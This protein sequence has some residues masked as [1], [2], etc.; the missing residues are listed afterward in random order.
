MPTP[1][2]VP[3]VIRFRL[4]GTLQ[5]GDAWGNRL[6]V[7]YTGSVPGAPSV[8][9][10]CESIASEWNSTW[11]HLLADGT[12]LTAVDGVDLSSTDGS[13]ATA[14]VS[15]AGGV[16]E[17]AMPNQVAANVRF[18]IDRRYRGG[19]PKAYVAGAPATAQANQSSW[20]TTFV[21]DM[22]TEWTAFNT[23]IGAMSAGG[24][25]LTGI[26]NVS[27]YN[28]FTAVKNDIT[29]RYRNVPTYRGSPL[30]DLVTSFT[31]DVVMGTQKRRRTA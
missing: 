24:C 3:E 27:F 13:G 25:D 15:Y 26:V 22:G 5:D 17:G 14:D 19:K 10:F 1:P 28:G 12:L 30:I 6:Y 16:A 11:G 9:S 23:A 29:G 31:C 7:L 18:D 8:L 4:T 21:N 20:T 2:V